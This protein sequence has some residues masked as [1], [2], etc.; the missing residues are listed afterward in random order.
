MAAADEAA[1]VVGDR[2]AWLALSNASRMHWPLV[3]PEVFEHGGST[4]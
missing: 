4:L 2:P 3:F 1:G